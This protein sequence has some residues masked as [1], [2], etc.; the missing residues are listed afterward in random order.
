M[1]K[2]IIYEKGKRWRITGFM[3]NFAL[4]IKNALF[5]APF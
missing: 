3:I 1:M 2:F 5:F 4:F